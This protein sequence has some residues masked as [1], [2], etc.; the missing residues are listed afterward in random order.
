MINGSE[1]HFAIG[2][3]S[4]DNAMRCAGRAAAQVRETG[5]AWLRIYGGPELAGLLAAAAAF[6]LVHVGGGPLLASALVGAWA[7]D[8]AFV[9][10]FAVRAVREQGQHHKH[11]HW[12]S[13]YLFTFWSAFWSLFLELGLAETV[14]KF[15]RPA[16]LYEIPR[17]MHNLAAG[18]I[19]AKLTADIVYYLFA[20]AGR[21][22]R[23]RYFKPGV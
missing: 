18:F 23:I 4:R 17:G 8:V 20:Y 19:V 3:W 10:Y 2:F 1:R 13:Y 16:L 11:R 9:G 21:M 12:V 5:K 22:A 15:V 7:E 6:G 14:D